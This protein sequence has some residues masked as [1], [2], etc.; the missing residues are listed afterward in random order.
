MFFF[1]LG[2]GGGFVEGKNPWCYF[3]RMEITVGT[4]FDKVS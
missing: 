3:G 4:V 1:F 2:G